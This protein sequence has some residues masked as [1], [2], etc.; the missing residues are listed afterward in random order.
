MILK[1]E[2]QNKMADTI[3]AKVVCFSREASPLLDEEESLNMVDL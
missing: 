1:L 2:L 3:K